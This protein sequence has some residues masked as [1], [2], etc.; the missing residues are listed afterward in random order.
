MYQLLYMQTNPHHDYTI[1]GGKQLLLNGLKQIARWHWSRE[2]IHCLLKMPQ[3]SL[4]SWVG[5]LKWHMGLPLD[6]QS[7]RWRGSGSAPFCRR[8]EISLSS[9]ASLS[10]RCDN[11]FPPP[12]PTRAIQPGKPAFPLHDA[13]R[14][15]SRRISASSMLVGKHFNFK[16]GTLWGLVAHYEGRHTE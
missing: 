4:L 10:H 16:K 15:H 3:P 2:Q 9:L 7:H 8:T 12:L 11:S 6:Y 14:H 1:S 5:T 13:P